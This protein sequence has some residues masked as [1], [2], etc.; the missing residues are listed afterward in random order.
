MLNTFS[1]L[2]KP[3]T[4]SLQAI[5]YQTQT[6]RIPYYSFRR[7]VTTHSISEQF[8]YY[9]IHVQSL[10]DLNLNPDCPLLGVLSATLK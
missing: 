7:N 1:H 5:A 10:A 4:T 9:S 3:I 8:I 6:A 2:I